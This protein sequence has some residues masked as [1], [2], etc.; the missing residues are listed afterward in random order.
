ML[1]DLALWQRYSYGMLALLIASTLL[2]VWYGW[3]LY[4][5]GQVNGGIYTPSTLAKK[6]FLV[7]AGYGIVLVTV[8]VVDYT[9]HLRPLVYDLL[10]W[11]H[12]PFALGVLLLG[13][14]I[15]FWKTG[16]KAPYTHGHLWVRLYVICIA[17]VV[18]IGPMLI[19]RM[20]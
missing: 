8:C 2:S 1:H 9:A 3:L 18:I 12:L 11:V 4:D 20:H 14:F 15:T 16:L 5:E 17:G 10:F 19:H 6:K 7:Y 13:T